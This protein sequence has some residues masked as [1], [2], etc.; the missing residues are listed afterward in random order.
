MPL[1]G[2]RSHGRHRNAPF[3]LITMVQILASYRIPSPTSNL[4][5]LH[6]QGIKKEQVNMEGGWAAGY[7]ASN[8]ALL[9][10]TPYI[11][12]DMLYPWQQRAWWFLSSRENDTIENGK[13]FQNEKAQVSR[14][15]Q[16]TTSS[17][18]GVYDS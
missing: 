1:K 5:L 2:C 15:I 13:H 10:P 3:M 11:K 18:L 6:I 16:P 7:L 14:I 9:I 17:T 4:A 12:K 8:L